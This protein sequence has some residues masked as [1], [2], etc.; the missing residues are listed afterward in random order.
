LTEPETG[1]VVQTMRISAHPET[2][3]RYWIDPER[4][5]DWWGAA[6]QL[7]AQEGG[8][9]RVEMAGGPIM[10]GEY[11]EL[12]PFERIV[13]TF[14]WEAT[15]GAPDIPPGSTRVE[16]TLA[17]DAGDTVL[18][19]RHTGVPVTDAERHRE[20]W[21][22]YLPLLADAVARTTGQEARP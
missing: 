6:V 1:V 9:C 12:V 8:T 14:G 15:D 18:T 4:M 10:R 16:V 20:G 13:F 3:W 17:E 11:I 2:V 19:L 5:C 21:A 22:L 7:D